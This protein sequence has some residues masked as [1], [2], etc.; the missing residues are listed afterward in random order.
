MEFVCANCGRKH[1]REEQPVDEHIRC[2]CGYSFYVFCDRGMTVVMPSAEVGLD[3]IRYALRRFV[4]STGRCRD[5]AT[6]PEYGAG[7][8]R[9]MD[10]EGLLEMGL[11]RFQLREMGKCLMNSADIASIFDSL[12]K[13]RDVMLKNKGTYVDIIELRRKKKEK[14]EQYIPAMYYQP[15]CTVRADARNENTASAK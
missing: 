1:T 7:F 10:P 11:E 2:A 13:D 5:T 15:E 4:M 14:A 3:E 9:G 12:E 6:E 8:L